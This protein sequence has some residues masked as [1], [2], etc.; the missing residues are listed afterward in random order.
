MGRGDLLCLQ[1][2]NGCGKTT[3]LRAL[4]G[5]LVPLSGT[6]TYAEPVP[7]I[8][9]LSHHNALYANFSVLQNL[10]LFLPNQHLNDAKA[11]LEELNL[12]RL[13]HKAI[14]QLSS[15]Q[16]RKIALIK[17]LAAKQ[18]I[19]LLDEPDTHLDTETQAWFAGK[20]Q[21]HCQEGGVALLASHHALLSTVGKRLQWQEEGRCVVV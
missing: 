17:I 4:A 13:A 5:L 21:S 15:G 10:A 8:A 12:G 9:Y 16:Q 20:V 19:W 11:L 18:S 2:P 6:V 7:Q 3:L 1:G 14:H